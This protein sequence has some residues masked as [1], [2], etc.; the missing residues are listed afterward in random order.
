[1]SYYENPGCYDTSDLTRA[2]ARRLV[3][4]RQWLRNR[5]EY[6]GHL[7][8]EREMARHAGHRP[9]RRWKL[10]RRLAAD[11]YVL[12]LIA[13]YGTEYGGGGCNGCLTRPHWRG[14]R[15]YLLGWPRE[16]WSCLLIGRHRRREI[17]G[18]NICA[19][20]APCW[21]CRST[22]PLHDAWQC[23]LDAQHVKIATVFATVG[24]V[25]TRV[26]LSTKDGP[27]EVDAIRTACDGLVVTAGRRDVGWTLTHVGTGRNLSSG[28]WFDGL[29]DALAAAA[30]LVDLGD[31]TTDPREWPEEQRVTLVAALSRIVAS[32]TMDGVLHAAVLERAP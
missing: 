30:V 9:W 28:I 14:R 31:F 26:T 17:P 29:A 18:S 3:E 12:G 20:C 4:T 27:D 2:M 13:S 19:V 32:P 16:R 7:I 21:V 25:A 10:T 8:A 11:A 22:D 5:D 23:D 24:D 1:M 15:P 6:I